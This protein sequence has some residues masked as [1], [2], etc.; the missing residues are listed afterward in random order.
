[1]A[2]AVV[3]KERMTDRERDARSG[4]KRASDRKKD[5]GELTQNQK[6]M[7]R[8]PGEKCWRAVT[9]QMER[10]KMTS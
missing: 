10:E 2:S 8:D 5:W 6:K 7:K 3:K 1:M 4:H 9:S